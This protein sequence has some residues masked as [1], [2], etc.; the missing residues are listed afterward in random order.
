M[1]VADLY[2]PE[3]VKEYLVPLSLTLIQ[4]K[5]CEVRL[6]AVRVVSTYFLFSL[7][8]A[9]KKWEQVDRADLLLDDKFESTILLINESK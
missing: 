4:D 6:A 3:D 7:R 2:E 8:Y 9:L 1:S 5:I